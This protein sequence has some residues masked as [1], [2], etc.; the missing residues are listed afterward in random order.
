MTL[1]A[2][3]WFKAAL[4]LQVL[5][6]GY[7]LMIQTVDLF[8]WN[9]V[10]SGPAS[11]DLRLSIAIK[12]LPLLALMAVFALGVPVLGV[13]SVAGFALYL[14]V[15]L[16]FWWKPYAWG[17]NG[18]EQAAYAEGFS[19]TMKVLPTYGTHLP[20]DTQHIVLHVLILLTL[21]VSA[22]AAARM[23]HL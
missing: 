5:L 20:P 13:V 8:P 10:V 22:I 18:E 17:A 15:Q 21:I 2:L 16:W 4:V 19:R 11:D 14:A 3:R 1:S 9:D 12:M 7:W 23:R 6:V